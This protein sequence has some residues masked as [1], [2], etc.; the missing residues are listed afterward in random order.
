MVVRIGVST[1]ITVLMSVVLSV[2]LWVILVFCLFLGCLD[3]YVVGGVVLLVGED[4]IYE[5]R[6]VR[7]LW[8]VCESMLIKVYFL[9]LYFYL[10]YLGCIL[11]GVDM[12]VCSYFGILFKVF[13]FGE[14]FMLVCLF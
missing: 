10:V 3:Y 12:F 5:C 9:E 14:G 13:I 4:V 2:S 1:S 11:W 8:C 7:L 6:F